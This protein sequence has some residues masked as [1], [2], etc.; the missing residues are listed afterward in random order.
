LVYLW[1]LYR[2]V[3]ISTKSDTAFGKLLTI[4]VGLPIIFQAFLNMAVAVQLFPVTGQTLPLISD[5]G[6]SIWMT[7]AALG[8][9]LGVSVKKEEKAE[10]EKE[11]NE[12]ESPL[13]VLSEAV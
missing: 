5:G 10:S 6:T 1:L 3:L 7:C 9:V 8:I 13:E 12:E 11:I 2:I 4:G